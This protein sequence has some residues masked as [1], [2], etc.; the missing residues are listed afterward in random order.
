MSAPR[1]LMCPPDHYGIAYEI[2]PWM[3]REVQPDRELARRQWHG[4]KTTLE[5]ALG[6][7]VELIAPRPGLPDM[8]FTANSGFV[9]G[10][11]FIP[12]RFRFRARQ[13]EEPWFR[14]WFASH[15]YDV[16]DLAGGWS[17]EG[18]GDA[19][20]YGERIF[21]GYR[22]RSDIQS[23]VALATLLGRE[24]LSLELVDSRFYH[25]DTCLSPLE[26]GEVVYFP[27]A[28]DPYG[29]DVLHGVVGGE[30]LL[31]V[32]EAEALSFCCNAIQAGK[33]VVMPGGCPGIG[34]LLRRCGYEIF[35][36]DLSEFLKS[37]GAAR[38]LVCRLE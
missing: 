23:H 10:R 7:E 25:L 8:V 16:L 9:A 6:A 36:C 26:G 31:A 13:G 3:H 30:R 34:E 24:V 11:L 2:N 38:C 12:A 1:F 15:G 14:E 4:L 29:I 21:A 20:P 37:G 33:R 5:Q 17:F 27:G 18:F 35:T 22:F 28:F 19:L 32:T